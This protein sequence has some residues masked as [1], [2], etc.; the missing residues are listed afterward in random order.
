MASELTTARRL[1]QSGEEGPLH[2][3]VLQ[4]ASARSQGERAYLLIRDQ[5]VT[6]KLAPG[7]VIAEASLR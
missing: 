3:V 7:S 2:T 1:R 6:L 5:I 4:S